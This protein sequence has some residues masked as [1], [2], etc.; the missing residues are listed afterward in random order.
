[1]LWDHFI[2][3]KEERFQARLRALGWIVLLAMAAILGR[4]VYL[5]L[6]QGNR[7]LELSSKNRVRLVPIK[8]QRGLIYDR[9][10]D[11][12]VGNVSTF[13]ICLIPAGL[14]KD[15]A[16]RMKEFQLL[17]K[18]LAIPTAEIEQKLKRWKRRYFEPIRIKTNIDRVVASLIEENGPELPG[19]IVIT[20]S[21]RQYRYDSL[22]FHAL[23]YVGEISENEL[24]I[25]EGYQA[26]DIIGQAGMEKVYDHYLKGRN[27][28]LHIEVD[29]LGRQMG[30][31]G[32]EEP[33]AGHNLV[34]T[35]DQKV[36]TAAETALQGH[37]GVGV[38]IDPRNGEVLA[39]ASSPTF[40]P[41]E[42][43]K[44]LDHG[45][46]AKL[47]ADKSHPLTNR[48]IQGVYPPG[49]IF[50]IVTMMAALEERVV[51]PSEHFLCD[52]KFMISTWPY[53]CWQ[54]KGH[55]MVDAQK[56]LV[57][58]CD[59]YF[60]HTGLRLKVDR[61]DK[62][63]QAFG[64]G[65]PTGLD[66][67]NELSGL[68]PSPQ[69]KERMQNMPWF[70]GNT[71]MFAIGQGYILSTPLQLLN[72]VAAV[73]NHGMIY[74]PHLL[75]RVTTKSG[76]MIHEVKP[77]VMHHV[78][79]SPENWQRMQKYLTQVID[80]RRG[81]GQNCRIPGIRLGG[82]TATAQNPHGEDHAGFVAYGP[83]DK[84]E[85]A[86]VVYLENAGGGGA[87]AAPLARQVLEA[88]FGISKP[89]PVEDQE[90]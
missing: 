43:S 68:V 6:L 77:E 78:P 60:Y 22:A 27:G 59:I 25:R 74:R 51:S 65:K 67:P 71:V 14:P 46:W 52:G 41:N 44:G 90:Q 61:L 18:L 30:I 42:F 9:Q 28:W 55:W 85:I 17:E 75:K 23:G 66:L 62:W 36:Q 39:L 1:M 88:Y 47:C 70:P 12:L 76:R 87:L 26:G 58:S 79:A 7:Y 53:R 2:V 20:E 10:G 54:A 40:N 37:K 21:R 86:V 63:S 29:A 84:P 56:S 49:S 73:A 57:E 80:G 8:A 45:T 89:K 50:K 72:P 31:L 11:L 33:W 24:A 16:A 4:L 34:L 83:V 35:L 5:Q 3:R 19:V 81:T 64:L 82:K 69:W 32:R 13:S 15:P 48:A 38:A